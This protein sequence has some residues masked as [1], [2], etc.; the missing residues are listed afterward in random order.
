ME[1]PVVSTQGRPN[2][3]L[4]DIDDINNVHGKPES[5]NSRFKQ[6]ELAKTPTQARTPK[7]L[8]DMKQSLD[9]PGSGSPTQMKPTKVPMVLGDTEGKMEANMEGQTRYTLAPFS[10]FPFSSSSLSFASMFLL[11]LPL[12]YSLSPLR[13]PLSNSLFLLPA[14]CARARACSPG[15]AG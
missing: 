9:L 6:V 5:F 15:R 11:P 13:L 3:V 2:F 14:T 4:A 10:I 12:Y 1:C 7:R 8:L